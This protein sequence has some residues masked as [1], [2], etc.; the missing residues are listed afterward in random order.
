MNDAFH[1]SFSTTAYFERYLLFIFKAEERA[2][3]RGRETTIRRRN[4]RVWERSKAE[5]RKV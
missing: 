2:K 5:R 1:I 4:K 3:V